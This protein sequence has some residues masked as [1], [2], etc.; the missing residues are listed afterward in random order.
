MKRSLAISTLLFILIGSCS[1]P[2]YRIDGYQI[3]GIDISHHQNHINWDTIAAGNQKVHFAFI[4]ATEG[5]QHIDTL[6]CKNWA[7]V[8]RVGIQ[9][10]AYHFFRPSI[11]PELQAR[12]FLNWVEMNQHDLPPVLDVEV[13]DGVSPAKLVHYMRRWLY[14]VEAHFQKKPI[15][16]T[17]LNFYNDYLAG[18]FQEYPI[19][20]ARY[21]YQKPELGDNQPWQFWQYGNN[22]SLPG[23]KGAVDFNVFHGTKDEFELFCKPRVSTYSQHNSSVTTSFPL[24]YF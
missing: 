20:I 5:A 13:L 12:N 15:I 6:F 17:N 22:G 3:H 21:S 8:N 9:R 23:I 16:Y 4:K 24:A 18:H 19:W 14:V 7:E 2:T 11:L 10:G 1:T